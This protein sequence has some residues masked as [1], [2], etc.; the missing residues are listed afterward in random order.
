MQLWT[1]Y[2]LMDGHVTVFLFYS[3]SHALYIYVSMQL[4]SYTSQLHTIFCVTS[5]SMYQTSVQLFQLCCQDLH[6][7]YNL[8]CK[9]S[10]VHKSMG[11][12]STQ[13]CKPFA[14]RLPCSYRPM[15]YSI[16]I[17]LFCKVGSIQ[18]L[19]T[20]LAHNYASHLQLG[21]YAAMDLC[22]LYNCFVKLVQFIILLA[23]LSHNYEHNLQ[24]DCHAVANPRTI[25]K[26]SI[27][28][29]FYIYIF[30]YYYYGPS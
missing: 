5:F 6:T 25:Y 18:I 26:S 7:I 23:K 28:L 3:T 22:T 1:Y 14:G 11:Q 24:L 8:F 17:Q 2:S 16:I 12:V 15:C 27:N 13:L 19:W 4:Q 20:K 21:C 29:L 9:V 30:N 10:S